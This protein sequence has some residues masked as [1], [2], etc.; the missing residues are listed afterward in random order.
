MSIYNDSILVH[1][2]FTDKNTWLIYDSTESTYK[3]IV[4]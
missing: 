2:H 4:L 3:V 1:E